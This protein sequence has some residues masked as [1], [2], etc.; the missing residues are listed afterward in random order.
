MASNPT[1]K[2][3]RGHICLC[4]HTNGAAHMQ[5][6]I[7]L[8]TI[9]VSQEI[10]KSLCGLNPWSWTL[11]KCRV[12]LLYRK[13]KSLSFRERAEESEVEGGRLWYWGRKASR[14]KEDRLIKERSHRRRKRERAPQI[15]KGKSG[16]LC[17]AFHLHGWP[18]DQSDWERSPWLRKANKDSKCLHCSHPSLS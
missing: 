14:C 7:C 18:I 16:S 15:G 11:E 3:V 10:K 2:S 17:F 9:G 12:Q 1:L 6:S 4:T 13:K 8:I 5:N